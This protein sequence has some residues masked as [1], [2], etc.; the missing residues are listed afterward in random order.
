MKLRNLELSAANYL[1]K[2]PKIKYLVKICYL[3][4]TYIF[5]KKNFKI[6]S[7]YQIFKLE[8]KRN[9]ETFFGYYDICP[10]NDDGLIIYHQSNTPTH[11]NPN[12]NNEI[13]ISVYDLYRKKNVYSIMSKAFNWQQ[14]TR[15]QWLDTKHFIFNDFDE[16]SNQYISRIVSIEKKKIVSE[17]NYQVCSAFSNLFFLSLNYQR[18][19]SLSPEYGYSNLT[20]LS[21][22]ELNNLKNDGIKIINLKEKN[23]KFSVSIDDVINI[24]YQD[25]FSRAYHMIIHISISPDGKNFIFIHRYYIKN[26][27]YDRLMLC[28]IKS[29]KINCLCNE[30]IVSHFY[31]KNNEEVLAYLKYSNHLGYWLIDI[32]SFKFTELRI[33]ENDQ[34][35]HPTGN[36]NFF[37]SDTYPDKASMQKL[38]FYDFKNSKKKI[39]GEFFHGFKF[40][41][42]SRCDLHPRYC[43]NNKILF[44]DSIYSG[45]RHLYYLKFDETKI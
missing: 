9:A 1:S 20:E 37:I 18:I 12:L 43:E 15:A 35:G 24:D 23:P 28:N 2:F 42:A 22:Y 34:D 38:F 45:K 7:E 31:W 8:H 25:K 21:N 29:K 5:Y 33:S 3:L 30:Q 6:N 16:A 41:G 13:T 26:I 44:F 4:V 32:K 17:F 36:N 39:I 10:I 11:K 14:G 19:Y 40:R 27:R